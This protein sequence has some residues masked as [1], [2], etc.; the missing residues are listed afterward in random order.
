MGTLEALYAMTSGGV[1]PGGNCLRI[2]SETA[3][4][5]ATAP[6]IEVPGCM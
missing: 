5:C 3:A 4:T 6:A 1:A 2:G